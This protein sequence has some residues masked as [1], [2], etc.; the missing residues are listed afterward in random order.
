MGV[1]YTAAIDRGSVSRAQRRI[2]VGYLLLVATS[3]VGLLAIGLAYSGRLH[4]FEIDDARASERA[5]N[6]NAVSEAGQLEPALAVVFPVPAARRVAARDLFRFLRTVRDA[7]DEVPNVGALVRATTEREESPDRQPVVSAQDLATLKPSFVVRT[8]E[9]FQRR[10]LIAVV[11]F[12]AA[13]HALALVWRVRQR[14]GD[15]LL[16]AAAHLLT[17]LGFAILLSRPDPLRDTLLFQR[18]TEGVVVGLALM[19]LISFIDFQRA[20]FLE[21]S[22]VPLIGALSLS[23]LLIVFGEGPG[24]SGAKVNLGPV[25]PIEAIRLLLA[26]FLAGYF[27]RRWELLRQVRAQD[28]RQHHVP[29]WLNLPRADYV[30]PVVAGVGAS[31]VFFFLQKDLGPALFLSCVFLAMYAVARRRVFMA[32]AGL[33]FLVAGFYVGYRL[34]VS[35]ILIE[36]VRMWQSPWDNAVRGGAQVAQAIWALATGGSF[37]TGLGLGDTRYLPAGHTDLVLAALGEELGMAGLLSIAALFALIA[38]RGFRIGLAATT[39][40]GFFLATAVTLFLVLPVLVMGAGVLGITPLTGVVTPFLSYGGSA[41]AANFA[42]LGLLTAITRTRG[43]TPTPEPFQVPLRWLGGVLSL[44]AVGLGLVLLNV[45]VVH[46]DAYAVKGHL[47]LQADG[48]RRYQYNQRVVDVARGIARG[49]VYD[50]EGMVLATGDPAL[51]RRSRVDYGKL[52][53]DTNPTCIEPVERC[54]PLGGIAFHLLGDAS[55]RTN[56]SA[57][58]TSYVERDAEDRLRG[59]NDRATAVQSNDVA[60]RSTFTIKRDYSELIPLLRHRYRQGHPAVKAFLARTRDEHLTVDARLQLRVAGILSTYASKSK[61]F[62][63]AVIVL[64]P[65]SGDLLAVASYPWPKVLSGGHGG[66]AIGSEALLDRARYGLYPPGSTFKLVTA[67]AALRK[68]AESERTAFTCQRL[69]DGRIGTQ[70][71]GWSRP[72][73]DDIMDTHPHGTIAMH[74]GLVQSCNAYFAQLA[75]SVGP[76]ALRET[77]GRFGIALTAS[78]AAGR[79]HQTLP[80]TGY[81]QGDVLATPL[82]MAGVAAVFANGGLVLNPRLEVP[83]ESPRDA[84]KTDALL[85]PEAAGLIGQYMRDAVLHGTGRSLKNN[86]GR[87]AGKTGTAEVTGAPSHSWFVGFAPFGRATKRVAFAVIIEHA[88]YGGAAAAPVAGEI[89]EAAVSLGII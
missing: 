34:N 48:V 21:L 13:F 35:A 26:L 32:I 5:T 80:Q 10:V 4:K 77:A 19:G 38:W 82:K 43:T 61:D 84:V 69:P 62:K 41:M 11:V 17:A 37:G 86:P 45:Q 68:D 14:R 23:A 24:T 50:R 2:D 72:V 20:A 7:G 25:Q 59:F 39:D 66:T 46:A 70:I 54:Y 85:T 30:L 16:L 74:D 78:N 42:A 60:G 49:T 29:D 64:D 3:L 51:A 31:L 79:L 56:W 57:S 18:Y 22:Y 15:L 58:N 65:H 28:I 83:S 36:R 75:V 53:L 47:T 63:A 87:I 76:A 1:S 89:I 9:E 81:G 33:A 88:G 44:G 40:Y 55:R 8:R 67:A 6:L 73:R 27:S 52:G 12:I 71:R